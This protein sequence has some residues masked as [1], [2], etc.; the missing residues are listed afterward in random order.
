MEGG[1]SASRVKN[2]EVAHISMENET[3][4]NLYRLNNCEKNKGTVDSVSVGDFDLTNCHVL[5]NHPK[6]NGILSFGEDDF[7]LMKNHPTAKW[8]LVNEKYDYSLKVLKPLDD[9]AYGDLYRK[10][11][12][13]MTPYVDEVQD[14]TMRILA[15]RGYIQYDKREFK[16]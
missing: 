2:V 9:V 10:A 14:V 8:D 1:L 11:L 4:A 5:H 12:G 7:N 3:I 16:R 6:E 15:E 13:K